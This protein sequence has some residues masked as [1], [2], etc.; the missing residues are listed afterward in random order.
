[1]AAPATEPTL[2]EAVQVV[3]GV[4]S[5]DGRDLFDMLLQRECVVVPKP[6][7][8]STDESKALDTTTPAPVD[9]A[10]RDRRQRGGKVQLVDL[11]LYDGA[12]CDHTNVL[13]CA[14][15]LAAPRRRV[16]NLSAQEMSTLKQRLRVL[17]MHEC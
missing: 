11:L 13:V 12:L 8:A 9:R 5:Q 15:Q 7:H 10:T 14:L 1:M 3:R 2:A 17:R 4:L 16:H 6:R